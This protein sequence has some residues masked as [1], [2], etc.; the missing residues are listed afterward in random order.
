M[1]A[2]P[3]GGVSVLNNKLNI[4]IKC[5]TLLY[6]EIH[7]NRENDGSDFS[8]D[9]V[10]SVLATYNGDSNNKPAM[11]NSALIS[12]GLVDFCHKL[13]SGLNNYSEEDI[14]DTM[15]LILKDDKSL[16]ANVTT[17][18]SKELTMA[19]LKRSVVSLRLQL[20]SFVTE[21]TIKK[22]IL[23][24]IYD[25]NN[26]PQLNIIEYTKSLLMEL[27]LLASSKGDSIPGIVSEIDIEDDSK[28]TV[29][30]SVQD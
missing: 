1:S 11:G 7:I 3:I 26:T 28:A 24:C 22:K 19:C 20:K 6:R 12:D 29:L 27:D 25:F 15:S 30:Q 2:N 17:T 23:K 18:L 8:T 16:L 4:L 14:I 9:L 5:V 13:I 21:T 10:A